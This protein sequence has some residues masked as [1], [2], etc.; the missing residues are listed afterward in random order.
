MPTEQMP[1]ASVNVRGTELS[2]SDTRE[3]YREK[4]AR[5]ALDS[6]VQFVGLLDANGTV[7]EIN[8]VALDAVGITLADVEGRPFWETFWW[9]VSEE[10]N[11]RLRELIARASKGEFVRW[12]TPIYGRAGGKETIIIDGSLMPVKDERDEVVF[13]VAEGRDITEKK[14]Y[15]REIARQ[16]EE[17]AELD[18]LKTQFFAN[19]S[20][21]FRTPLT[22]MM[23][24]LEDALARPADLSPEN[25]AR[26]ELAHRNAL[27]QLKLV[28]ALLEFSRIEAG[29]IEASFEPTD[30]SV[31][32]AE[33]AS[34][35]RSAVERAG[36]TLVVDCP[37]MPAPVYVDRGMWEKV[38]LNLLSNAFKF[39]FEGEIEVSLRVVGTNVH[40]TIRDTGTGI[41][42]DELPRLFERFHR[43]KN[44]RGRSFEGSGI[45]LALVKELVRLHNGEV[46]VESAVGSGSVFLVTVPLG[47]AHLPAERIE[48]PRTQTPTDARPET[49]VQELLRWLPAETTQVAADVADPPVEDDGSRFHVL[50]ADDNSDMRE[51]IRRLLTGYDVVAVADGASALRS[52]R[53]RRP[54]LVLTDV[55]MPGVDGFELMRELRADPALSHVPVI[56]LSARAGEE[57]RIEG[58]DAGADEYLVKP[59]AA[60][61]LLA[62]VRAQL[63]L[64]E[65]RRLSREAL[66]A[67]EE[68]HRAFVTASSDVVYQM[69]G[70]WILMHPLDGRN[71]VTS[72]SNPIRGW[73]EKNIPEF[74]HARVRA[75]IDEAVARKQKFELEHQVFGA[76]GT[77]GWTHS[78]AV[79]ILDDAGNII[80]WFGTASDVTRRK[81]AEED[82]KDIRSRMEA[83]LEAGAIGTWAWD[84]QADR[85]FGD[86]SLAHIFGV[87]REAVGG[88][89]LS[90]VA[91]AIHPDDRARVTELVQNAL[92]SGDRYEAD[93][94]V[95]L[96]GGSIRW[97]TARGQ[98]ERDARGRAVRFPGVVIDVTE[99]KLAEAALD[100]VT[101]DSEKLR[102]L[103][104]T[105]L[106]ATPDFV[107][108]FSLDHRVLYANESL[109]RMWGR[110]RDGAIGKTFLEIGYEPWHADMHDREIDQVRAT[111][112]PIRGEVPFTGTNGR[113]IYDYIFVPVIG[114]DGEVEAVAGTTRDVTERKQAELALADSDRKKDE[115]IALLAHELRNPLAPIRNGVQ[116][117]RQ[118]KDPAV[119][120][121]AQVMMDRQLAHMVRLIDDLL[122]VSRIS[123]N[124]LELR[125]T[126]VTLADV[127]ESAVE[128]AQPAIDAAG[129]E[130]FVTVP[131]RSVH[132]N[133]D[134]TRLAQ[135]LSNL[136]TNSAKYT[137]RGGTIWLSAE[138]KDAVIEVTIKDTG[139]GIPPEALPR[140]FDMF[141]Q[142][143]RGIERATG[144]LGIGLALVKG[145]TEMHGG[146][147]VARSEGEGRGSAFVV[148][149]PII[150]DDVDAAHE[151]SPSDLPAGPARRVL[152]VD[153]NLDGAQ[154]LG[155]MLEL[156][157]HEVVLAHDGVEAIERAAQFRPEVILMDV[158]M[159]R[160]NGLDA[161]RQIRQEPWGRTATIIALTGWGQECDRDQSREAGCNGHLVKPVALEDL[162]QMLAT[163]RLDG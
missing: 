52:A 140:I 37:P 98:V 25:R 108:V 103:Y 109:I 110:G 47:S 92:E 40:L 87:P 163:P 45:G 65:S 66:R 20:H 125:R 9:Q 118:A 90:G 88:G 152:V 82:L 75:A 85:F 56:L 1:G 104:E 26:L 79:P 39:T 73:M 3:R 105:V 76:D 121:R 84:V 101:A 51:Y 12:D 11:A 95:T 133:A 107:Y 126:R 17:L 93:Y 35:F 94:R 129:H 16:R 137:E 86:A 115:F 61:E 36:L 96:P 27:R 5:I 80:E 153:D 123:R 48:A 116:V 89:P 130:L 114:A 83:A 128:A 154:S 43:V 69:S 49:F 120:E 50:V 14:A 29:R 30:L 4:I 122:D 58:L 144:G 71:L 157:G 32:T 46:S 60:R 138:R 28:N 24:P 113:R 131:G 162:Y 63:R 102:R 77:L 38:V 148:T 112:Q 145:L 67:S 68:R 158:G 150:L 147:V 132:L 149:L 160:L 159:P 33:L 141:S 7:L 81:Q 134:L 42:A 127:V 139:I 155:M 44:A 10:V 53:A 15:E 22:L 13:I 74:E 55:M 64:A 100:R 146:T 111:K 78:R 106:S 117:L 99:R 21:E 57:S 8:K 18:K 156:A 54:D 19:I 59:F 31:L 34:V 41:P 151:P 135:V 119:R 2:A 161:T 142:V 91:D 72:N 6:M 124:K 70:D 62:C 136:L 97:V 143:D 23:G